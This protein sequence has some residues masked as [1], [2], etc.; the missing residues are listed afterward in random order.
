MAE[1]DISCTIS[2]V[3]LL[4]PFVLTDPIGTPISNA[5]SANVTWISQDGKQRP[6]TLTIP[7]SAVFV[8][9]TS[10]ADT[11]S[12]HHE[13]GYLAVSFG[14]NVFFTSSFTVNVLPHFR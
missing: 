11:R 12:P 4:I 13:E 14:S 1:A 7:A 9:T 2:T 6:L 8:Y 10:I 5:L 3:G